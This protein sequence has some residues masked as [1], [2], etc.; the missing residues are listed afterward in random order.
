MQ[1]TRLSLA[2]TG[3]HFYS[4]LLVKASCKFKRRKGRHHLL[5]GGACTYKEGEDLSTI[6]DSTVFVDSSLNLLIETTRPPS[7]FKAFS[8]PFLV[9]C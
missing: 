5:V 3:H 9:W 6:V 8:V 1:A 4:V 7:K 2:P